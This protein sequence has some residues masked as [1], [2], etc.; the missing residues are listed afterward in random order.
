[1]GYIHQSRSS[2]H[3]SRRRHHDRRLLGKG[4]P[5]SLRNRLLKER[6]AERTREGFPKL[7]IEEEKVVATDV[8]LCDDWKRG[9]DS[10]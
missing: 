4:R 5:N 9:A 3:D 2:N 6:S 7:K 1:M 8:A 10:I